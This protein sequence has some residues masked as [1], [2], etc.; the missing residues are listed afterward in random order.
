MES[1]D[2]CTQSNTRNVV[3]VKIFKS[4]QV[5]W[6]SLISW[7]TS[8]RKTIPSLQIELHTLGLVGK[9]TSAQY[10]EGRLLLE[11]RISDLPHES[12]ILVVKMCSRGSSFLDL[13][14]FWRH[15]AKP[16]SGLA[17]NRPTSS[18]NKIDKQ[19]KAARKKNS[20]PWTVYY[21]LPYIEE[22]TQDWID[23]D[24]PTS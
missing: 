17:P 21:I 5:T 2:K 9:V 13:S 19:T 10:R 7:K 23:M 14:G 16:A 12:P 6:A 18:V 4:L 11:C 24:P 20:L 15:M 3:D 8:R 22:K 1:V